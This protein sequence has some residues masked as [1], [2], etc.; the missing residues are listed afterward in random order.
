MLGKLAKTVKML[1]NVMGYDLGMMAGVSKLKFLTLVFQMHRPA[2]SLSALFT[3]VYPLHRI[4]A[5]CTHRSKGL[6]SETLYS[7]TGIHACFQATFD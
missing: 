6:M 1:G 4:G 3:H 7:C 2:N 5:S